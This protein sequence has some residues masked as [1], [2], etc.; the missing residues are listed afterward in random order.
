MEKGGTAEERLH[1]LALILPTRAASLSL[2]VRVALLTLLPLLLA[3]ISPTRAASLALSSRSTPPWPTP[4]PEQSI[5][6]G[7]FPGVLE[8]LIRWLVDSLICWFIDVLTYRAIDSLI[9]RFIELLIQW[10]IHVLTYR[11]I[12]LPIRVLV[13]AFGLLIYWC[14]DWCTHWFIDVFRHWSIDLLPRGHWFSADQANHNKQR[15]HIHVLWWFID[16]LFDWLI[17]S[18]VH[19]LIDSLA[20]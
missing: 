20:H 10:L 4:M 12:D 1:R 2:C 16:L 18:L 17:G 15:A 8:L 11:C 6:W 13:D 9:Y 19:W 14:V 5:D 7:L 3:L